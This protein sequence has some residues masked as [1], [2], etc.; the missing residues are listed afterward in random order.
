MPAVDTNLNTVCK[1]I[2]RMKSVPTT[3]ERV[4]PSKV[5]CGVFQQ[6]DRVSGRE[7]HRSL[8]NDSNKHWLTRDSD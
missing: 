8:T 5:T 6:R 2:F 4:A 1:A 3:L 7:R